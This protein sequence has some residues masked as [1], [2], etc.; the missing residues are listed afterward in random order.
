MQLPTELTKEV[1]NEK[2]L[3]CLFGNESSPGNNVEK[4]ELL[5]QDTKQDTERSVV[6][7]QSSLNTHNCSA[8]RCEGSARRHRKQQ[9]GGL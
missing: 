8:Q 9:L 1:I 4:L 7:Q 2:Q 6:K 3:R 5:G